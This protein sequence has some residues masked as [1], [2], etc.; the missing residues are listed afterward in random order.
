MCLNLVRKIVRVLVGNI[1]R[2]RIWSKIFVET[3]DICSQIKPIIILGKSL[4][5]RPNQYIHFV[6]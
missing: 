2:G 3:R 1:E 5:T 4:A 6:G